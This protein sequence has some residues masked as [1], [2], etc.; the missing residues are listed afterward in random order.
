MAFT[1]R[2]ENM[3]FGYSQ[4]KVT[5]D[6]LLLRNMRHSYRNAND[7]ISFK[8]NRKYFSVG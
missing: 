2:A 6:I 8:K 1:S 3:G 5:S 7:V 4:K